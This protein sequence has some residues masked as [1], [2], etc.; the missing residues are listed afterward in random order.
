MPFLAFPEAGIVNQVLPA[1]I[2]VLVCVLSP[3]ISPLCVYLTLCSKQPCAMGSL[4]TLAY[5][6]V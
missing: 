4:I 6:S 1:S 3:G 2:P 5:G